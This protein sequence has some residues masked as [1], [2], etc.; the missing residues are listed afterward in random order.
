M[1]FALL[2]ATAARGIGVDGASCGKPIHRDEPLTQGSGERLFGADLTCARWEEA[3]G[4]DR[5]ARSRLTM[6][7]GAHHLGVS[8]APAADNSSLA[9]AS[10]ASSLPAGAGVVT[11]R[12]AQDFCRCY[13]GTAAA[14]NVMSRPAMIVRH[15]L[16]AC[17]SHLGA[18][19]QTASI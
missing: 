5:I 13:A 12:L 15:E 16:A 19:A 8:L 2:L 1:P 6:G 3:R 10:S 4:Q 14:V 7:Q 11:M 9:G 18:L 17:M